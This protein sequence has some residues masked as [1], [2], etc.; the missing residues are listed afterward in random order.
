MFDV[1]VVGGGP[2]GACAAALLARGAGGAALR[3]ALLEP[4]PPAPL[5]AAAPLRTRVVALSR[6]SERILK[7]AGAWSRMPPER[8]SAYERM[9]VWHESVAPDSDAVLEFDAADVGEPNLGY[10]AENQLLQWALLGAFAEAGGHLEPASLES[11]E[12]TDAGVGVLTGRGRL[13]ARLVVGADGAES[14]V[15][16]AAGIAADIAG[17]RQ[18]AII[19]TVA[20]FRPHEATAWQRFMRDGTLAFLPLAD[21]TSSIVWSAD[22]ELAARLVAAS[23]G[24]FAAELDRA[25]DLALGATRL[26]GARASFPLRRLEAQHYVV[27][28]VALVGDAAHVVHPLAGQG[29]NLGL[30]DAAALA[31][32]V[33]AATAALAQLVRA[34]S[35]AREDPGAR[36]VLR[37]YERWRR[38]EVA[39]M[40]TAIDAFDRWLAHGA[41]PVA[42]VAQHG[43][44]WVNRSQELRRFFIRRALGTSGELPEA[45]R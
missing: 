32:L 17:Y 30:A 4:A 27:Q 39:L 40:S 16:E 5:P 23:E 21:G 35:A 6:A 1:V 9:R 24:A 41:G 36:G 22:D 12:I 44:A 2:V 18:T 37:A 8:V 19:A 11:L 15:R 14:R 3:V 45:A 10:I 13:A 28:R 31:Q 34:A 29:V 33:R 25:S 43:L 42:R 26:L 38:S 7:T 20:T